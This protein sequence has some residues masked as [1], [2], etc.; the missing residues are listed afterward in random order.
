[1]PLLIV[2]GPGLVAARIAAAAGGERPTRRRARPRCS[3]VWRSRPDRAIGEHLDV[4]DGNPV[5]MLFGHGYALQTV[6]MWIIFFCSLMN[7]FLFIYWM[8]RC[9]T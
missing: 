6:L 3:Q 1:M 2:V 8:P 9:C 5:K 4:A 7:L